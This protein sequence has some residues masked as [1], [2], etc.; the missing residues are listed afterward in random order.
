MKSTSFFPPFRLRLDHRGLHGRCDNGHLQ[1]LTD[2]KL[3]A[4]FGVV[5]KIIESAETF[6]NRRT[7][8]RG[9]EQARRL[10]KQAVFVH[11]LTGV[12]GRHNDIQPLKVSDKAHN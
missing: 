4:S 3:A 9:D 1:V 12:F 7:I 5:P 6:H 11:V 2:G 8:H 10:L